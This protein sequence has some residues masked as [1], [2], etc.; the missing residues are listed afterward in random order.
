MTKKKKPRQELNQKKK[1][2]QELNEEQLDAVSGGLNFTT[3][4][5]E[6][7]IETGDAGPGSPVLL[8]ACATGQHI[9][10]VIIRG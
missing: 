3:S 1:L 6:V 2:R 5:L 10:K 4:P 7:K 9:P 8:Q